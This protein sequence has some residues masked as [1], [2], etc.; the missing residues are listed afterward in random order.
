MILL[1]LGHKLTFFTF[2]L[3]ETRT[4]KYY[5][6]TGLAKESFIGERTY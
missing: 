4:W 1:C 3:V 6:E 2:L 5:V